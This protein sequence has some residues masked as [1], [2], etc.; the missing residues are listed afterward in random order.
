MTQT[1]DKTKHWTFDDF[2][3]VCKEVGAHWAGESEWFRSY[4][5]TYHY[6]IYEYWTVGGM[7]G[8]NCW[9]EGGHYGV[10]AEPE[11]EFTVLDSILNAVVPEIRFLQYKSL[12]A[13]LQR[14]DEY[15]E[16]EYYGNYYDKRRKLINLVALYNYLIGQGYILGDK[17]E[18]EDTI[19][20]TKDRYW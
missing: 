2:L 20:K 15:T 10:T 9:S 7:T 14:T 18:E 13:F 3:A 12:I 8:G 1:F 19:L 5:T 11:P 6:D 17:R 4:N 16:S